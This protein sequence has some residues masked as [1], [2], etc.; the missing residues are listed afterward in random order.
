MHVKC[1]LCTSPQFTRSGDPESSGSVQ[2]VPCFLLLHFYTRSSQCQAQRCASFVF[3]FIYVS[4]SVGNISMSLRMVVFSVFVDCILGALCCSSVFCHV[5]SCPFPAICLEMTKHVPT[6]F[7]TWDYISNFGSFQY[8]QSG[9]KVFGKQI[10][11]RVEAVMKI[12]PSKFQ[13][14]FWTLINV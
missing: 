13:V 7:F 6:V 2:A 3:K 1:V 9:A 8:S 5:V 12:D 11:S 14:S 10:A 4:P